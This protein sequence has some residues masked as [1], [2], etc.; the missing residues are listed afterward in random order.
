MQ[1]ASKQSQT[2]P[3][4]VCCATPLADVFNLV[5]GHLFH[6]CSNVRIGLQPVYR[7]TIPVCNTT[8]TS[9]LELA[10][11]I[12]VSPHIEFASADHN[13]D[14]SFDVDFVQRTY[15]LREMFAIFSLSHCLLRRATGELT[16]HHPE[17]FCGKP[18]DNLSVTGPDILAHKLRKLFI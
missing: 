16:H 3:G 10:F 5:I 1:E 15:A 13:T 8:K 12:H 17:Q 14:Y 9:G 2:H 4:P 6:D 18:C 11:P 7:S